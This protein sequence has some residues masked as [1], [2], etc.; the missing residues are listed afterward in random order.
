MP[1]DRFNALGFLMVFAL[2]A[3]QA[4]G[5]PAAADGSICELPDIDRPEHF[6]EPVELCGVTTITGSTPTRIQVSLPVEAS[7]DFDFRPGEDINMEGAGRFVGLVLAED[8]PTRDGNALTVGML[9]EDL[10]DDLY[11]FLRDGPAQTRGPSVAVFPP[12][13]YTLFFIA[14]G[15]PAEVTL[16]FP[17]LS[18]HVELSPTTSVRLTLRKLEPRVPLE[19]NQA[20]FTARDYATLDTYG[21]GFR[22]TWVIAN[23]HVATEVGSCLFP[24]N[25]LSE[26]YSYM[27]GLCWSGGGGSANWVTLTPS[28]FGTAQYGTDIG[29]PPGEWGL[30]GYFE[31]A[32]QVQ[33][34]GSLVFWLDMN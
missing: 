12:G 25:E 6:E 17:E 19:P 16:R 29:L 1:A 28:G 11:V 5:V 22:I 21:M 23:T 26:V 34:Y 3:T 8:V 20:V 31:S 15:S 14:D 2:V 9:P 27:P 30:G 18:G 32:S 13:T 24:P 7:L 4:L 33:S 10:S